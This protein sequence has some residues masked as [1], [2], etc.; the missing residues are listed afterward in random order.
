MTKNR[1]KPEDKDALVCG[2]NLKTVNY[3][4]WQLQQPE[5]KVKLKMED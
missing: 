3:L 4:E 2:A 1:S 5:S